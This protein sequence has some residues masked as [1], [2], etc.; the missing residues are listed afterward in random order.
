MAVAPGTPEC[1]ICY[2]RAREAKA[3][4]EPRGMPWP[5]RERWCLE[6]AQPC[7]SC[8]TP[9]YWMSG[10]VWTPGKGGKR[11]WPEDSE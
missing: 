9:T 5:K 3:S 7:H 8:H 2:F 6:H 10:G 11:T 4:A 1:P